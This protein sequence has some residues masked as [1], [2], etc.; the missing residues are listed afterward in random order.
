M[1]L[2]ILFISL[3]IICLMYLTKT[4]DT[5]T[6]INYPYNPQIQTPQT[7]YNDITSK[8]KSQQIYKSNSS[9]ALSPTP[10]IHCPELKNKDDCNKYGCNWFNTFCSSTYPTQV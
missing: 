1:L 5:F 8:I 10:T 7:N 6:Q 2:I 9:V 3:I 4:K